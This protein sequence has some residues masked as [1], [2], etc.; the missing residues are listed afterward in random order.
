MMRL[1]LGKAWGK[2]WSKSL[3]GLA[4]VAALAGSAAPA[5][6]QM[7]TREGIALQ[8][9]IL[10][11]HHELEELRAQGAGGGGGSYQPPPPSEGGGGVSGDLAAQLLDRVS[12][13][14]EAVR[15]LRGRVDEIDNARQRDHDALEKEIGDLQFKLGNGGAGAPPPPPAAGPAAPTVPPAQ[16]AIAPSL[17]RT[18]ERALQEGYIALSRRDYATAQSAAQEVLSGGRGPRTTDAQYLLAQSLAGQRNYQAAAV[19][20]DD[21]YTRSPRGSRAPDSLVG[22]ANSLNALGDKTAACQTLDKLRAE[23]PAPPPALRP[24]IVAARGRAACH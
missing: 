23:F 8:N 18:P 16:A 7:E 10:E 22:L 13:L 17:H 24:A 21:T 5:L 3:G 6:A 20:F 11:L 9:Q 19:A 4:L 2:G 15:S 14:E 1:G 12:A